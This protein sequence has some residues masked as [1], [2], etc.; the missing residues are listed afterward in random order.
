M[1]TTPGHTRQLFPSLPR[2]LNHAYQNPGE[3]PLTANSQRT[4][5]RHTLQHPPSFHSQSSGSRFKVI[6][7]PVSTTSYFR[8]VVSTVQTRSTLPTTVRSSIDTGGGLLSIHSIF[9][10][11]TIFARSPFILSFSQDSFSTNFFIRTR[12]ISHE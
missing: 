8:H 12:S 1:Q 11:K 5:R 10:T 9:I 6:S 7:L 2:C 4:R 3:G